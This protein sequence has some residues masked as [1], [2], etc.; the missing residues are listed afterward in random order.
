ME[1]MID[2]LKAHIESGSFSNLVP[3]KHENQT[4]YT[5]H[6][7]VTETSE[8]GTAIEAGKSKVYLF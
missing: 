5:L 4:I 6:Y 1:E 7:V 2:E 8:D 3:S